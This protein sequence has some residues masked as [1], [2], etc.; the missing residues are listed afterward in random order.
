MLLKNALLLIF[1]TSVSVTAAT[2]KDW[3]APLHSAQLLLEAG[4]YTSARPLFTEQAQRGNGL[5]QFTLGLFYQLGWGVNV[6]PKQ[7]CDWFRL[8]AENQIPVAQE[9]LGYCYWHDHFATAEQRLAFRWFEQ[10]YQA[11]VLSAG[12]AMGKLLVEGK[13]VAPDL[14]KGVQ[15][16]QQAAVAGATAAQL[17]LAKWLLE[18]QVLQQDATQAMYWFDQAANNHNAE[19]AYYLAQF[20]DTGTVAPQDTQQAL[21]WYHTAAKAGVVAAYLPTAALYFAQY[22]TAA[23]QQ[24]TEQL[25]KH[26]ATLLAQAYVW[27]F[28]AIQQLPPAHQNYT[29]ANTLLKHISL[30]ISPSGQEVLQLKTREQLKK[31]QPITLN[32]SE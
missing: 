4:D 2:E 13:Y 30:F 8:A 29:Q 3:S 28:A 7:S 22:Q 12:C 18:G 11:G 21:Q 5:A 24:Q 26:K 25:A 9:Q 10:A 19:A 31:V 20:Y 16:C 23:E 1:F 27:A 6:S 15:L 14:Y 32:L 17:Q